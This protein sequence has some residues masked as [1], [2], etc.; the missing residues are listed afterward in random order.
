[1]LGDREIALCREL[2]KKFETVFKTTLKDA[3][4]YYEENEPRGEYVLVIEGKSR[5]EKKQEMIDEWEKMSIEEHVVFYEKQGIEHKEAMKR[6]AKDRG[7]SKRDI[8]Q[9]LI[10]NE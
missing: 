9:Y 1:M 3:I 4:A 8:Y 6:V 7:V 10:N 2:T 5:E